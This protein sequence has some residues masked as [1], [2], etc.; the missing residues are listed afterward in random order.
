MGDLPSVPALTLCAPTSLNKGRGEGRG[1]VN[2]PRLGVAFVVFGVRS[3][4]RSC[5][6]A[7]DVAVRQVVG[8]V[9]ALGYAVVAA[10]MVLAVLGDLGDVAVAPCLAPSCSSSSALAFSSLSRGWGR[11]VMWWSSRHLA[12][13]PPCF[14]AVLL[15]SCFVFR[16]MGGCAG[17]V[18][19]VR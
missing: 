5:L 13:A 12:C 7:I 9:T 19:V 16:C 18:A 14:R 10:F 8:G 4:S 11:A 17:D 2:W 15:P 3:C 6:A 1:G